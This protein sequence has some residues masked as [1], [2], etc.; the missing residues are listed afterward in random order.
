MQLKGDG[1]GPPTNPISNSPKK[2]FYFPE[3][4]P[5]IS[6]FVRTYPRKDRHLRLYAILRSDYHDQYL[7]S[8]YSNPFQ[9]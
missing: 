2:S 1:V 3:E 7:R 9:F 8:L 4:N 5:N 6:K